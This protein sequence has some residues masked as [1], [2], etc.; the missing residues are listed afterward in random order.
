MKALALV[1]ALSVSAVPAAAAVLTVGPGGMFAEIADAVAAAQPG[2]V[3]LVAPGTYAPFDVDLPLSVLGDGTGDV[4]VAGSGSLVV[5]GI[6]AG[7]EVVVSGLVVQLNPVFEPVLASVQVHDCAGTVAL[8]DLRIEAPFNHVGVHVEQSERVLLLASAIPSGGPPAA[9]RA[10]DSELWVAG[11]TLVG[12]TPA[13][14]FAEPGHD[15]VHATSST[16][17]IWR[18]RVVGGGAGTGKPALFLA[19]DGGDGIDATASIVVLYGGPIASGGAISGGDGELGAIFTPNGVGGSAVRLAA[20]SSASIQAALPL[21]GGLDGT[22]TV[23]GPDV[24]ADASSSWQA[25]AALL[26]TLTAGAPQAAV[27]GGVG[28]AVDGS[29]GG[30]AV[31]FASLDTGPTLAAPRVLGVGVLNPGLFVQLGAA[32]LDGAGS[33]AFAATVPPAPALLGAR[34]WFQAAEAAGAQVAITN[35]ALVAVTQ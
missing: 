22:D 34:L 21:A 20:G 10:I 28:L 13:S 15:A 8:H 2:D 27:G 4:V 1:F 33:G 3:V 23:V 16:L 7:T 9:V 12:K 31:L 6:A 24:A 25:F 26:P 18:S 5:H 14:G 32:V 19:P 35:P 30:L 11:C 17:R 29:P